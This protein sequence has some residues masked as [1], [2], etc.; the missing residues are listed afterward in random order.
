MKKAL[1]ASVLALMMTASLCACGSDDIPAK[2]QTADTA[3]VTE[4]TVT[5]TTT[6]TTE[7]TTTAETTAEETTKEKSSTEKTE[8]SGETTASKKS[9][10]ADYGQKP[11][12][13]DEYATVKYLADTYFKAIENHDYEKLTEIVDVELMYYLENG[14]TGSH[15][16]HL[17]AVK[18]LCTSSGQSSME[19]G[20]PEKESS[21]AAE[22][23]DFFKKMDEQAGSG[24]DIAKK[25][26]VE[27]AYSVRIKT[28]TKG[29]VGTGIGSEDSDI[30]VNISGSFDINLDIDLP[31]I[32]INGEW[33]CDPAVS[34]MMA[35][36]D[37]FM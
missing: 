5:E 4:T 22:Y 20:K 8:K 17:D 16:D 29:E 11:S 10:K 36:M 21:A 9:G 27:D 24:S 7:L 25:F 28:S 3:A 37:I 35:V 13:N 31:I 19:V 14:E 2:S 32:K 33:K 30:N 18:A 34:M 15:K 26:K 1:T 6:T 12:A 23:N